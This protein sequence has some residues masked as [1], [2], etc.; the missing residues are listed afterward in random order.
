MDAEL[1]IF[2]I[3]L[4]IKIFPSSSFSKKKNK[5]MRDSDCILG[6][7]LVMPFVQK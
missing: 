4:E 5:K 7:Y 6:T 2:F 1:L 3:L